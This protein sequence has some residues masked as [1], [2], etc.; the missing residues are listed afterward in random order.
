MVARLLILDATGRLIKEVFLSQ[1]PLRIG[2]AADNDVVVDHPSISRYHCRIEQRAEV[3]WIFDLE[4]ANGI[5]WN[6]QRVK[7]LPLAKDVKFKIGDLIGSVLMPKDQEETIVEGQASEAEGLQDR[8]LIQVSKPR[9]KPEQEKI[10]FPTSPKAGTSEEK[11][12]EKTKPHSRQE[13]HGFSPPAQREKSP[14]LRE[15]WGFKV[16]ATLAIGSILIV[17]GLG[18]FLSRKETRKEGSGDFWSLADSNQTASVVESLPLM[19]Q[20]AIAESQSTSGQ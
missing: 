20:Q 18:L 6:A 10:N 15:R 2:R 1:L 5:K 16:Q 4:S 7:E 14:P 13:S 9:S 8:T 11:E 12:K 19:I 3:I 17:A